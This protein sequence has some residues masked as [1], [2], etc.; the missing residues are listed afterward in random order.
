MAYGFI[1]M[2]NKEPINEVRVVLD[3]VRWIIR[4]KQY[5]RISWGELERINWPLL[6][7]LVN[8]HEIA[9]FAYSYFNLFSQVAQDKSR[10]FLKSQYYFVLLQNSL[11][12]DEFLRLVDI[13]RAEKIALVPIK[14]LAL[15]PD[16][17][18]RQ[19]A[20][21]MVDMDALVR[22]EELEKAEFLLIKSGYSKYLGSGSQ[23]YWRNNNCNIPFK[24]EKGGWLFELHF[25]LDIKRSK[26]AVL[27]KL[28][29][30]LK[31]MDCNGRQIKILSPEDTLFSLAL[32]QRRFGRRL[33]LKNTLDTAL[34]LK[35]YQNDFDWD[36]VLGQAQAGKMR[37]AIFFTLLQAV[38]FLDTQIPKTVWKRLGISF[39]KK[40]LML[41]IIKKHTFSVKSS[42]KAKYLYLKCHFL[43][44]DSLWLPIRHLLCITPEEFAKFYNLPL[45]APKTQKLYK[46][47]FFYGPYKMFI[48]ASLDKIRQNKSRQVV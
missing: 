16:V 34:L 14:G 13:F 40:G 28:W 20:R 5:P 11:F 9:P 38:L 46:A 2:Q 23:A 31:P 29:D 27:P 15:L 18:T 12:Q 19:S 42:K 7:Q 33:C 26:G 39:W 44:Y 32:H 45:Y 8:Y 47:R 43:L 3:I 1:N 25:A 30:R 10:D 21:N 6:I 22:E 4:A 17:Y 36:Y 41:R 48:R 37:S 24:K 35:K